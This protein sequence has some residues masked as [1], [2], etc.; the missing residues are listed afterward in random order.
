MSERTT[1]ARNIAPPTPFQPKVLGLGKLM[2]P[3]QAMRNIAKVMSQYASMGVTGP[4][5]ARGMISKGSMRPLTDREYRL[6]QVRRNMAKL[7]RRANRGR[8]GHT[9]L[10]HLA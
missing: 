10:H 8:R 9:A 7:S 3:W 2:N 5:I 1:E 6:R 4:R